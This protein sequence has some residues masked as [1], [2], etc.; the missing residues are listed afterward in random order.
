MGALGMDEVYLSDKKYKV[1]Y[2]IL[3]LLLITGMFW[4]YEMEG[5]SLTEKSMWLPLGLGV[6]ATSLLLLPIKNKSILIISLL[7]LSLIED[8]KLVKPYKKSPENEVMQK[9]SKW[10]D[11]Q[12]TNKSSGINEN[13]RVY[14][15]HTLF[16]FYLGK[17]GMDFKNDQKSVIKEDVD[18]AAIGDIIIWESHYSYR[19][20]IRPTS[21]PIEYFTSRPQ[22][23]KVLQEY[24]SKDNRFMAKI[25]MK[26]GKVDQD[27]E[28]GLSLMKENKFDE[29]LSIFQKSLIANPQ[30]VAALTQVGLAFRQKNDYN[31]SLEYLNKALAIDM[32][33]A[34]ALLNRGGLYLAAKKYNE[35]ITDLNSYITQKP[36]EPN[37]YL[38]RGNAFLGLNNFQSALNDF[39]AL[40]QLA[41]DYGYGHLQ[42]GICL[43]KLGQG[44]K[45]CEAFNTAKAKGM[46]EADALL[47]Q[48]C[49]K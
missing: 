24:M 49:N 2:F 32:N 44:Q 37:G 9:I 17:S 18:S 6:L 29:A 8:T 46:T 4:S 48:Y 41:P 1:L 30:N 26:S 42:F 47:S 23:Y 27:F 15:N 16:N 22:E 14:C 13:T 34:E 20:N 11:A 19:P 36:N 12:L 28:K 25:F 33:Y 10:Y 7:G 40:T 43:S 45:A 5:I 3:P 39:N 35:T 31:N 21:V 38:T